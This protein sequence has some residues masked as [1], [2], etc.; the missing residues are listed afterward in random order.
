MILKELFALAEGVFIVK[1][2]DG[3][4]K[5]FKD[6]NSDEALAWK[7]SSSK[8]ATVKKATVAKFSQEWWDAR[9]SGTFPDDKIDFDADGQVVSLIGKATHREPDDWSFGKHYTKI[10]DGVR[11][12]GRVVRAGWMITKDDDLGVQDE[13]ENYENF[14]IVRDVK[15]PEKFVFDGYL[16]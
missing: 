5:R 12:A 1:N 3:K 13:V 8:K 6:A 7:E 9:D 10:V 11:V 4:E 14:G 2:K 15:N 16:P